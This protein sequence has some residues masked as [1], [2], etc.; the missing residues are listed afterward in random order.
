MLTRVNMKDIMSQVQPII[1]NV[2]YN[3][4]MTG[5]CLFYNNPLAL[6]LAIDSPLIWHCGV[7]V[8]SKKW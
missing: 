5:Y 7:L 1:V 3:I 2:V 4:N 6:Q 8:S